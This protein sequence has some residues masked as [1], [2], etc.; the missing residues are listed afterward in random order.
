MVSRHAQNSAQR[1]GWVGLRA[2]SDAPGGVEVNLGVG[3]R[4]VAVGPR[5]FTFTVGRPTIPTTS[6]GRRASAGRSGRRDNDPPEG[7]ASLNQPEGSRVQ[8][9]QRNGGQRSPT[10]FSSL[11][12]SCS[13]RPGLG[14]GGGFVVSTRPPRRLVGITCCP[15]RRGPRTGL[16][17]SLLLRPFPIW[18]GRVG[19]V[20]VP[21][22]L[23]W[24]IRRVIDNVK[25]VGLANPISG[26]KVGAWSVRPSR[27][28]PAAHTS[29]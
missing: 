29:C 12:P 15:S 7:T 24:T 25:Q 17:T 6:F 20:V 23:V 10:E 22:R 28:G 9:G 2:G 11:V 4:T 19:R 14:P 21:A 26:G 5:T 16:P 3:S 1:W 18:P 13:L 8:R 27:A